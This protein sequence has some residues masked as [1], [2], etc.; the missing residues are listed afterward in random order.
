MSISGEQRVEANTLDL[1]KLLRCFYVYPLATF[2]SSERIF[3]TAGNN[4]V[5]RKY[6]T[7]LPENVY[8]LV[9]LTSLHVSVL[10]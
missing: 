7:L 5:S 9:F 2:G 1:Q 8:L 6:S 4:N 10:M 3:S